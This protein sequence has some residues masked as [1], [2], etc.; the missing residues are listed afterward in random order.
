MTRVLRPSA[1][2]WLRN[3]AFLF[4]LCESSYRWGSGGN[5]HRRWRLRRRVMRSTTW[6]EYSE[7]GSELDDLDGRGPWRDSAAGYAA[8]SVSTGARQLREAREAGQAEDLLQLLRSMM[9]RNHL[10]IDRPS[11]HIEC[12]VG[13]KRTIEEFV[14]EQVRR[15]HGRERHSLSPTIR[16]HARAVAIASACSP[17][18]LSPPSLST[19]AL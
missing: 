2:T 12:R 18:P 5:I 15:C 7:A 14:A 9:V 4:W 1:D 13:T 6:R 16:H 3:V 8:A 10:G 11:L 17:R 19:L